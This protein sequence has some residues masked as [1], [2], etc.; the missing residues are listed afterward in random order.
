MNRTR[1]AAVILGAIILACA[2]AWVT[3]GTTGS[4]SGVVKDAETGKPLSGANIV[5]SNTN[6]STVTDA[7][8]RYVV[9][10]VP[11][12]D[13]EITAQMVGYRTE[14]LGGV[15]VVM[16]VTASADF[17]MGQEA[18][19]EETVVV[20]RPRPMINPDVVN[21]FNLVSAQQEPLTRTD[22]SSVRTAPGVLGTLPGVSVDTDGSGGMHLRGGRSNQIGWYVEGIP[23]TDPNLGSFST[24][25]F[26]TG[27]SKFQMYTGPFG[28]EYGNAISGAFNEVKKTG[29]TAA[30]GF[31]LVT[32]SGNNAYGTLIGEFAGG[33]SDSFNYYIAMAAQRSDVD[34]P[35][36]TNLN[37]SDNV[38]KLVWPSK[39]DSVTL[40]AM[41]G[42]QR[43]DMAGD[44]TLDVHGNTV[45]SEKDYVRPRYSITSVDWSHNLSPASFVTIQ[46]YTI[47][48]TSITNSMG[49]S[50]GFGG[51]DAWSGRVG[52]QAKYVNQLNEKHALKLGGSLDKSNN[53]YYYA[54][55]DPYTEGSPYIPKYKSNVDTLQTGLF[56]EDQMKL[57]DKLTCTAGLRYDG[58]IYDRIGS[59]YVAGAGYSGD[60]VEDVAHGSLTPRLG[61]SYA[62]DDRSAW[63]TSWGKYSRFISARDVQV[64]YFSPDDPSIGEAHNP[65]MAAS[66]PQTSDN[67][68]LTYE[69][70]ATDTL[71]WRATFFNNEYNNLSDYLPLEDG[72]WRFTNL[73]QGKSNGLEIN[74]RK[75]MSDKWQGWLSYTYAN[76]KSNR[77]DQGL[78]DQMYYTSW[79]QRHTVSLIAD[80]QNGGWSHSLRADYGSGLAD[81]ASDPSVQ[82]RANPFFV[83]SYNLSVNLPEGSSI[84]DSLYVSVYNLF[85]IHQTLQYFSLYGAP[86]GMADE[87]TR[88]TWIPS[89][90]LAVGVSR[91]F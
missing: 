25:L 50:Y 67:F 63:K 56:A 62:A 82:S 40:F 68:E 64:V 83:M 59:Q 30:P 16:D 9:T 7:Q 58:I 19:A 42:S 37:Y 72:T 71:A 53:N 29:A 65:G 69:K 33:M 3:A 28:A 23:I 80:Y 5:I 13:Y 8:G 86:Y 84:G 35:Y 90:T 45:A 91:A 1:L 78:N 6:L 75:K 14:V 73:G 85:N 66:D 34:A 46:P 81:S 89:R 44:H 60:P 55:I 32:E 22:P 48:F 77:A 61:L 49:G 79:D 88:N 87:R 39:K 24:N 74:V 2:G 70:Q 4:V 20:T 27:M 76:T 38:V 47:F 52:L 15:Q 11:P 26:T 18:I 31:N 43:L 17:T 41:Q 21:T 54:E 36:V 57:G 51:Q 12:G 10:N